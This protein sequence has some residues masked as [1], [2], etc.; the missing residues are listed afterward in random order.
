MAVYAMAVCVPSWE[1]ATMHT[2]R[3]RVP[4]RYTEFFC[5]QHSSPCHWNLR[6]TPK[7]SYTQCWLRYHR[8]NYIKRSPIHITKP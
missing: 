1:L 2:N 6:H 4:V 8:A 5:G 3:Q 7:R